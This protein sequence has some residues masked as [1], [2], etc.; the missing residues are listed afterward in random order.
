ML[1]VISPAKTLDFEKPIKARKHSAPE[2][3]AEAAEL[4]GVMRKYKPAALSRLMDISD[5]L[6]MENHQRFIE[7]SLTSPAQQRQAIFA[8]MGDVYLGLE[9]RSL[10]P[11]DLDY[12]QT[13]LRILCGLY[14]LLRPLDLIQPY[15]LEMGSTVK[16]PRGKDLYAY[17]RTTQSTALN[18][19]AKSARTKFL[20]NLASNEY[21]KA[22]DGANLELE[23]IT[24]AFKE[25]HRGT[26]KMMSFFA[27]RARG[28]MARYIIEQR[29]KK[30][31]DLLAF[32]SDGYRYNGALSTAQAPAFTREAKR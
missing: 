2:F 1:V 28:M 6:A 22:V 3:Q 19:L 30:P 7:W 23:V 13:H 17:W 29:A 11:R 32:D 9:A 14:G 5:K 12:A 15:R 24:P 20:I 26:Y 18:T 16:N 21:F 8:F 10:A 31:A 25:Y 4:I 27:K